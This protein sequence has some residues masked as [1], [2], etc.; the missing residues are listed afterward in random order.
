MATLSHLLKM[1]KEVII[2]GY[3]LIRKVRAPTEPWQPVFMMIWPRRTIREL[4][5]T[6][7]DFRKPYV[8][9]SHDFF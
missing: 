2:C 7:T 6:M 8:I 3:L 4:K 5:Y 1:K 9:F